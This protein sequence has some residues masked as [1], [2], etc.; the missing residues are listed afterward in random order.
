MG[1]NIFT[2]HKLHKIQKLRKE[3]VKM[4]I[5]LGYVAIALKLP[6]VTSSST[7]TYTNYGKQG[8]EENKLNKLKKVTLSNLDDLYKILQY[9]VENNIHF[10]R[11]TSALVPLATHPDVGNWD[12]RKIFNV[13]FKRI[14]D[15][16]KK[17]DMRVDT[18]PDEFN[19]LNSIREEVVENTKRNLWLHVNLFEDIKYP[20]GKM[21]LHIGSSQEGKKTA[22]KRFI[23]NFREFPE[24]ITRQLILENDDK[25]FT[26][27][28]V[29]QICKDLN[30]PMVLDVHHHICNNEGESLT[31]ML[32]DIF[33]TWDGQI[34]PPK[35]H[36]SSPREG[37]RDRKHSDFINPQDFIEFLETCKPLG[38]NFDVMLESKMK[39]L[40]LF[41]LVEDIKELRKDWKW[42][43]N[44]TL[45][46]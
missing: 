18:H 14:G 36:F 46:I 43:D 21:I 39:D 34:L 5:R 35:I 32:K 16:I 40:S 27:K 12:Y 38:I 44:T 6:K 31:P 26:T 8:N 25:T 3:G 24:E 41:K 19:V 20:K 10:Y 4:R 9:N 28:E 37:E 45:E 15:F 13:D 17:N 23:K 1:I 30:T 29:L 11:I 33:S 7:V 2:L 42:I 22:I